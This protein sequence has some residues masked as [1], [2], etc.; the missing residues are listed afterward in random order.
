MK[1]DQPP[2]QGPPPVQQRIF[3]P[4]EAVRYLAD[5][6]ELG[7][8]PIQV[9]LSPPARRPPPVR[10]E[11]RLEP[12]PEVTARPLA[13]WIDQVKTPRRRAV[14]TLPAPTLVPPTPEPAAAPEEAPTV[15]ATARPADDVVGPPLMSGQ[16]DLISDLEAMDS[17]FIQDPF[18]EEAE[19]AP[20]PAAAPVVEVVE[21]DD[22]AWFAGLEEERWDPAA[23]RA[24]E[25]FLSRVVWSFTAFAAILLMALVLG[26]SL[27]AN[28]QPTLTLRALEASP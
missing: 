3:E 4:G 2:I 18:T 24:Q 20:E 28:Q 23:M 25:R 14:L 5:P 27:S 7:A 17:A 26:W 22:D 19:R 16:V 1:V 15:A 10:V 12:L 8:P 13:D 11:P 6:R 9:R 21:V